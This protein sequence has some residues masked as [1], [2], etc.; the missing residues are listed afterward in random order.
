ML[1]P[2]GRLEEYSLDAGAAASE[3]WRF[4]GKCKQDALEMA[5][6]ASG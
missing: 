4:A 3:A 2:K 6:S 1:A 5:P